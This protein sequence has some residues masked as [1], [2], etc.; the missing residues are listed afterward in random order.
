M[1]PATV[2]RRRPSWW[3]E[4]TDASTEAITAPGTLHSEPLVNLAVTEHRE[5]FAT[6]LGD[7]D[8]G[9]SLCG[10]EHLTHAEDPDLLNEFG[11]VCRQCLTH[12]VTRRI[13]PPSP[14]A[15]FTPAPRS[16]RGQSSPFLRRIA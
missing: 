4:W 7:P 10:R 8:A 12:L 3:P 1:P 15:D 11:P 13:T 14:P 5:K 6:H 2:P 16:H 9:R